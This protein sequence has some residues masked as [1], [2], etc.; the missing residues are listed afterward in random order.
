VKKKVSQWVIVVLQVKLF[1]KRNLKV[2][3]MWRIE[4]LINDADVE[5]L[6]SQYE[7]D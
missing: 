6:R 5:E 2:V 1:K 4:R 7:G 3:L